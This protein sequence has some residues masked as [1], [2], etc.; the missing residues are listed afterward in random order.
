MEKK[1]I[2]SVF[3]NENTSEIDEAVRDTYPEDS[4]YIADGQWLIRDASILPEEIHKKL[5]KPDNKLVCIINKMVGFYG[6][7]N[8]AVWDWIEAANCE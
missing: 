7:K 8:K 2:Y 3:G 1:I 4:Y 5:S 6:W